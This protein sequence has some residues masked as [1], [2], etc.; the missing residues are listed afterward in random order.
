MSEID[1]SKSPEDATH[2]RVD[3]LK[4][5]FRKK[6]KD[7]CWY[8]WVDESDRWVVIGVNNSGLFK[9]IPRPETEEDTWSGEGPPPV[10]TVC[11]LK[12]LEGPLGEGS[13]GTAEILYSNKQAIVW[14]WQGH[15][16]FEF[17]ANFGDVKCEPIPTPEQIAAEEREREIEELVEYL[18][19]VPW[20]TARLVAQHLHD[21]GY[22]KTKGGAE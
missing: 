11:R 2:A 7:G 19:S 13:W 16:V 3:D 10:G 21:A 18:R 15:P 22:R 6:D 12:S 8:A 14:R 4:H 17:G 5:P 20:D 9:Y 1:W